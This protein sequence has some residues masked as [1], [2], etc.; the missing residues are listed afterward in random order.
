MNRQPKV[1]RWL[2]KLSLVALA[3]VGTAVAVAPPAQ[4]APGYVY[5][6]FKGDA[7]ADQ[8]LW[9]YSSSNG[10]NFS[11]L[12]DTKLPRPDRRAARPQ[13]HPA[14]RALLHRPVPPH[15]SLRGA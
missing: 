13:H 9:V 15:N 5:T 10:T 14:Q 4:A 3:A 11:V 1:R 6:T 8:E 2:A 12:A 7:A